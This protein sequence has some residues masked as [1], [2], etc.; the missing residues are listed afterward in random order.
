MAKVTT[1]EPCTSRGSIVS[2]PEG[3]YYA[4]PNGLIRAANGSFVNVTQGAITKDK[5]QNLLRLQYLQAA[6]L[7]TG[8]YVFG[9]GAFGSFDTAAFATSAFATDDFSGAYAG[10]F[11][12]PSN[13]QVTTTLCSDTPVLKVFNDPWSG[14]LMVI[15]AGQVFWVDVQSS[16]LALQPYVWRS[17]IFQSNF[18]ENFEVVKV[19]LDPASS[20]TLTATNCSALTGNTLGVIRIY[21]DS[22]L[23]FTRELISSGEQF[24]LP[25]GFKA[26]FWQ[27]EIEAR[28]KVYSVQMGTTAK[29][30]RDV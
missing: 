10:L 8:Y 3:V 1:F 14:E 18:P 13:P 30:L 16:D 9:V 17:K 26:Q 23:V 15:K 2:T 28:A 29:E 5:W 19:Y 21:A 6:R 24:R 22:N 20:G 11:I 25:S 27:I 4:S 12:D 7:G